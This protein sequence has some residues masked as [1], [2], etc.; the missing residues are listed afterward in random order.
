MLLLL[1]VLFLTG[2][3]V[4]VV[5]VGAVSSDSSSDLVFPLDRFNRRRM[6]FLGEVEDLTVGMAPTLRELDIFLDLFGDDDDDVSPFFKKAAKEE[7]PS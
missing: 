4:V 6:G 7:I 5:V 2:V 3:V 1:E